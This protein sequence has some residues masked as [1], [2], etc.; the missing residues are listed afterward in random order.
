MLFGIIMVIMSAI[1]YGIIPMETKIL[2]N[3]GFNATSI[4]FFRFFLVIPLILIICLLKKKSIKLSFNTLQ[5]IFLYVSLPCGITML[6]LNESYNYIT[7]GTAS[8]LHFLYPTFVILICVFYYHQKIEK[9]IIK[10]LFIVLIGISCFMEK[11]TFQ[12]YI[13]VILAI[14]SAITYAIYL[15]EL[16]QKKIN[17]VDPFVLTLYISIFTSLMLGVV[18][19]LT[20]SLFEKK[21]LYDSYTMLHLLLISI[22]S[23]VAIITLQLGSRYL[24]AKLTAFLSLFEPITSIIVGIFILNEKLN[25]NK[26]IGCILIFIAM[27][28]LLNKTEK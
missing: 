23:I 17:K 25:I 2:L 15:I 16:E 14:S 8:T 19:I 24:G 11:I 9:K 13:G 10:S 3:Y 27:L 12:G 22:L 26:L 5:Q 21:I 6:I 7:V 18:G 20:N 28:N 1:L 4:A